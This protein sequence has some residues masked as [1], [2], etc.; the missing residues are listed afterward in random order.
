MD[1]LVKPGCLEE[2]L[3]DFAQRRSWGVFDY[4]QRAQACLPLNLIAQNM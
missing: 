3:M 4:M 1:V 2:D